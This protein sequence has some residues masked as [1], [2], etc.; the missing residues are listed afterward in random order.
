[1]SAS[2]KVLLLFLSLLSHN[3]SEG[4]QTPLNQISYWVFIPYVYNPAIAG[5]K[6]FLSLDFIAS[7][8]GKSNTQLIGGNTRFS[9]TKPG[10]FSSPD[11]VEFKNAGI[12]W[13]AF[14]D[15]NGVSRHTGVS[16]AG[17]YQIPLTSR[18]LNFLTFGAS[19]KAVYN[20]I[21]T[22]FT[23]SG[24]F[25]KKTL[26]PNLDLGI[27]YFGTHF[28]SGLSSTNLLGNPVKNDS[29]GLSGASKRF[30]FSAGYRIVLSR[31]YNIV[32]EPS[33]LISTND[34]TTSKKPQN[35]NPILKLYAGN[36]SI[37]TYFLNDGKTSFFAQFKYPKFYIGTFYELPK[38]TPYFK[39]TPL[40]EL[41][42]GLNIQIDKTRL[43][44]QSHW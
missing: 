27:Y 42:L 8:Q 43:S 11:I 25:S 35:I 34:S 40:V 1:M 21:D 13:S 3:V 9:K 29:L 12:G 30:Y 17:S 36:F 10:Y 38:K 16:V 26:Y 23:E 19:L 14:K 32:L 5:S 6:D 28:F 20:V 18:K 33:L 31:S 4:Q 7:F 24:S 44:D 2:K 39:R 41:T 15:V 22:S 37:G